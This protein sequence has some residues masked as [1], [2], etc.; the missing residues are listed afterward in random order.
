M[1]KE[2][3]LKKICDYLGVLSKQVEIR[4]SINLYDTNI[5]SE[6][7]YNELLNMVYGYDLK[8][9]NIEDT[10]AAAID[11]GDKVKRISV[12]VTSD[13]RSTKVKETIRKFIEHGQHNNYDRLIFLML[14]NKKKYITNFDTKK[15]FQFDKD[16]DILDATDIVKF[17]RNEPTKKLKEISEFL[18]NEL[19]DVNNN[20]NVQTTE[21]SEVETIIDLIEHITSHRKV[22]K[23]IDAVIDPEFKIEKRF[24]EYSERIKKEYITLQMVYN[25]SLNE[26]NDLVPLDDVQ[27]LIITL[28]LQEISM[29][30]LEESD[31]NPLEALSK[32]VDH[33][34]N[35]MSGNGKKYDRAAI[36]FYLVKETIEC[37][38]FPNERTEYNDCK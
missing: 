1:N 31:D 2:F 11:L 19:G 34:E 18:D 7:F 37:N 28:Y 35:K 3:H 27:E 26:I 38:I 21:A 32:L 5:I 29:K 13:N 10:N 15:K 8:N 22:N 20:K 23:K 4:N 16:A 33:F 25:E 17:L 30:I 9:L 6:D 14:V 12:Q 36:K 24:L